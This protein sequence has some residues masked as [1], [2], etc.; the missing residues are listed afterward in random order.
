M[1]QT[2][3]TKIP[4]LSKTNVLLLKDDVGRSKP[5]AYSLPQREFIYGKPLDR[6]AED[7]KQGFLNRKKILYF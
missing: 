4:W 2:T 6:D 5:S 7:A 3:Y 1:S